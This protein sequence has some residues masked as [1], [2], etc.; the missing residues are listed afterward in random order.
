MT[1]KIFLADKQTLDSVKADTQ[2]IRSSIG[3]GVLE[4]FYAVNNVGGGKKTAV[5]I[6]GKGIVRF[7]ASTANGRPDTNGLI[8]TVDGYEVLSCVFQE[9]F[10]S[11]ERYIIPIPIPFN[12]SLIIEQTAQ[13]YNQTL[14]TSVMV[15][16]N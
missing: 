15:E 7:I 11:S 14:G 2:V 8:I 10:P 4:A 3:G 5:D 1:E 12:S 13:F 16:L 6:N 9:L